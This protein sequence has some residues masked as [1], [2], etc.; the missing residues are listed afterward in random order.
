VVPPKGG[1]TAPSGRPGTATRRPAEPAELVE[2]AERA[3]VGDRGA[4]MDLAETLL[5]L[6]LASPAAARDALTN[7][8]ERPILVAR[9]DEAMR[10]PHGA[11]ASLWET[12]VRAQL[13]G[14]PG[15]AALWLAS[16][17]PDGRVREAAVERIVAGGDGRYLPVLMLR[18]AD[19][20]RPVRDRARAGLAVAVADRPEAAL[21]CL[22]TL[23]PLL[24]RRG[25]GRF[26]HGLVEVALRQTPVEVLNELAKT[27]S[28]ATR[29]RLFDVRLERRLDGPAELVAIAE[30]DPDPAL[31]GRAAEAA[32]R[33]ALWT[34]RR[35]LL[36]RL[37][38][39]RTASVRAAGLVALAR[40]GDLVS[41]AARLD[42]GSPLV[43]ALARDAARMVGL[44]PA[45]RY[46]HELATRETARPG[47]LVG[48]AEL[49]HQVDADLLDRYLDDVEPRLRAAAARGLR[50]LDRA[51]APRLMR[52]LDD[53]PAVVREV[54][55][56]LRPRAGQLPVDA[57]WSRLTDSP[58]RHTRK[59]AYALL[60][61]GS[62]AL[63]RRA[64]EILAG[65]ADAKLAARGAADLRRSAG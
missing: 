45:V 19:W 26:A 8:A 34:G 49:G 27:A 54:T 53:T 35:P 36:V 5:D 21:P 6:D 63:R 40:A 55:A 52:L 14:S 9:V 12:T 59:A 62:P 39:A 42:D 65:D 17:H 37:A 48:L 61:A 23:G 64:A 44:D 11:P 3:A 1:A 56:A 43:R 7:L 10:D 2:L 18:T 29:R 20:V 25:R 13:A 28:P 4:F 22:L 30:S 33:E 50:L 47:A 16:G 31:R 46:R 41:V 57:L 32:A 51:S 24:E 60:V 15:P 58:A 38:A